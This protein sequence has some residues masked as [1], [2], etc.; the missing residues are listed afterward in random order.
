MSAWTC[1]ELRREA[2]RSEEILQAAAEL[3]L[4]RGLATGYS[5]PEGG[6]LNATSALAQA[7]GGVSQVALLNDEQYLDFRE[8][9]L[10]VEE[11]IGSYSS[12]MWWNDAAGRTKEDVAEAFYDAATLFE[13]VKQ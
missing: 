5:A 9:R 12:I 11:V 2:V 4:Q 3:V 10:A 8:V 6:P 13:G 1:A 7:V